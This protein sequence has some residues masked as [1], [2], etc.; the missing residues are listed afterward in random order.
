MGP[1]LP[2]TITLNILECTQI[3]QVRSVTVNEFPHAISVFIGRDNHV[4][5]ANFTAHGLPLGPYS[6]VPLDV[7]TMKELLSPLDPMVSPPEALFQS[8]VEDM[9]NCP[10]FND[11]VTVPDNYCKL[12]TETEPWPLLQ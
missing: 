6:T 9:L 8:Y 12:S 2:V 11:I 7:I 4:D 5:V 3:V 1:D 10:N